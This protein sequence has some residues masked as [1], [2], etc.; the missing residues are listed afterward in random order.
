MD[1]RQVPVLTG[2]GA[3]YGFYDLAAGADGFNTGFAFPEILLAIHQAAAADRWHDAARVYQRFLPLIVFEQQPGVAIR[4]EILRRRGLI[5]DA[6]VRHPG[7]TLSVTAREQL[8]RLLVH[9][10]P[11]Q[12][13]T[14]P[15]VLNQGLFP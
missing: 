12:D 2:L 13:I 5:A 15:L 7:G 11:D 14:R 3:L 1:S 6:T 10:L 8:D 9:V 4:K